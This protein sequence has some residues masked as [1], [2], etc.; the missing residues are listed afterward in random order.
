MHGTNTDAFRVYRECAAT[1]RSALVHAPPCGS[2]GCWRRGAGR[3]VRIDQAGAQKIILTS[4]TMDK[5]QEIAAMSDI[6]EVVE[7]DVRN[8]ALSGAGF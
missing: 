1:R 4:R 5:A 7:W 2:Y 8:D 3:R 6:I